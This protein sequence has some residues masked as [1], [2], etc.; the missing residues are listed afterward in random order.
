MIV[1]ARRKLRPEKVMYNAEAN[2]R[3]TKIPIAIRY[4][5]AQKR[6]R[7]AHM[8]ICNTVSVQH[9]APSSETTKLPS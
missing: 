2:H 3:I 5:G 1:V 8:Y 4:G 9:I 6:V 7:F